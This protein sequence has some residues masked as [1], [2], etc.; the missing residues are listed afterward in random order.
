MFALNTAIAI[1]RPRLTGSAALAKVPARPWQDT[2]E[3]IGLSIGP[4]TRPPRPWW[5]T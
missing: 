2:H 3:E 1:G 4:L 5:R